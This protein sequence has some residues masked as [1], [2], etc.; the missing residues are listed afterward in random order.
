MLVIDLKEILSRQQ[1]QEKEK[2]E[3]KLKIKSN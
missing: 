3:S 2:E 1:E